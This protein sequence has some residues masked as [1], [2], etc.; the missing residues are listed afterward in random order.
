MLAF[1]SQATAAIILS[2]IPGSGQK[3]LEENPCKIPCDWTTPS[4]PLV[5]SYPLF[6]REQPGYRIA[7]NGGP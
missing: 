4:E 3:I 7:R 2:G 5:A 6:R 1:K